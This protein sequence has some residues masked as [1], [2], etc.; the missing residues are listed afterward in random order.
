MDPWSFEMQGQLDE[1]MLTSEA[2]R[3]NPLRDPHERPLWVYLPPGYDDDRPDD[4][5]R[6][7]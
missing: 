6:S 7:T 2:L 3:D 4:T 1:H 5:R